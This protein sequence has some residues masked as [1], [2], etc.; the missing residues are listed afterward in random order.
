[1]KVIEVG[2]YMNSVNWRG[3]R[4]GKA[5]LTVMGRGGFVEHLSAT[6]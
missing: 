1:M 3:M 5:T 2:R 6:K 4:L